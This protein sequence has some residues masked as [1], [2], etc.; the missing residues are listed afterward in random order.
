MP[1]VP[2]VAAT[3]CRHGQRRRRRVYT[4]ARRN[5]QT[6]VE[7]GAEHLVGPLGRACRPGYR[8]SRCRRPRPGYGGP[9]RRPARVQLQAVGREDAPGQLQTGGRRRQLRRWRRRRRRRGGQRWEVG[10]D[11]IIHSRMRNE[12]VRHP[13]MPRAG[14]AHR[15]DNTRLS[16]AP[17]PGAR[18]QSIRGRRQRGEAWLC[19]RGPG[20]P[21]IAGCTPASGLQPGREVFAS[22]FPTKEKPPCGSPVSLV[23]LAASLTAL[24]LTPSAA[25]VPRPSRRSA[26]TP[27]EW[28]RVVDKA[29]AYLKTTQDDDG[30]W[31]T[32][33]EPRHH[34]HR[35]HR[36][37]QDRQGRPPR[38]RSPSKALKY[39]EVA[40]QPEGRPHRRQ[41]PAGRSCRTTSPASTSWPWSRPTR[42]Q[43]QGGHRRRRRV[44]Q[45]AAVGRGEGKE[46]ERRLLRRR[47]LRQQVA[48]RPVQ[49]AVLPR[50]P[51]GRRRAARTTRPSRRRWSSS[52]AARTSRAST[53]T[54]PGPARSTTAASSTRAAGGGRPRS[55]TSPPDG[56]L[57]GYG[58]MTYAG[59]KS[60]IYCG[61]AKDD[62]RIKKALRVD[63]E[64]LH[65]GRATPA[66]R[67]S[68][69]SGACTTT[70]TRW[71]SAS[72]RWASTRSWTP[73]A[74]LER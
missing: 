22:P 58:S 57:P 2:R 44:P 66:C 16:H 3:H 73:R 52:A 61:V 15:L 54:S 9:R 45:E 29:I 64:E 19:R 8:P 74:D 21:I 14:R 25:A 27:A 7:D 36:P 43:V 68:A 63:P 69:R 13:T 70:T 60:M 30:S 35:P 49:H 72:T 10:H 62:P 67:R 65:R 47:R 32:Q 51:E 40:D 11:N 33:A 41:G 39:I 37:A 38:T 5:T 31:S 6:R 34:R 17:D 26:P 50:R 48:A 1:T 28:D 71:P 42:R 56:G 23:L 55:P 46:P 18:L 53:T 4:N 24:V 12:A 59:I 20:R